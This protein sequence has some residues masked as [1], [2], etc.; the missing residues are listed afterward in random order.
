MSGHGW[1]DESLKEHVTGLLRTVTVENVLISLHG[2]KYWCFILCFNAILTPELNFLLRKI[3]LRD[4]T[5]S[6]A[7]APYFLPELE[8]CIIESLACQRIVS[9]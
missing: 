4:E 5:W 1:K 8:C 7:L 2:N 3:T 9:E 6:M